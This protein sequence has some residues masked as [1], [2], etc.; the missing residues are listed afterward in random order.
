[1]CNFIELQADSR[2]LAMSRISSP[3]EMLASQSQAK[4][5]QFDPQNLQ[6]VP[7]QALSYVFSKKK[8][9][10]NLATCDCI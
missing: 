8:R 10:T 6:N 9:K 5:E 7:C 2:E 3:Q 1:M 4:I